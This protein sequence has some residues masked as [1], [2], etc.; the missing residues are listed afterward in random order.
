MVEAVQCLYMR[1]AI[2]ELTKKHG[3]SVMRFNMFTS[4]FSS[5]TE[6][7]KNHH[8]DYNAHHLEGVIKGSWK[9]KKNVMTLRNASALLT[10]QS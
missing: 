8:F 9:K 1:G 4:L 6:N 10:G 5:T 7:L 3:T 2:H